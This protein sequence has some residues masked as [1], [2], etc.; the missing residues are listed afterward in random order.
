MQTITMAELKKTVWLGSLMIGLA[1]GRC[2][3]QGLIID[4]TCTDRSQIPATW[5]QQAQASFRVGYSHTS[6]GSQIVTGLEALRDTLGGTYDFTSSAWGQQAGVFLCDYWANEAGGADL[7]QSGDLTWRDA[8]VEML[9]R[10]D[11][12]RNLVMWSWCGGVSGNTE[13]GINAYLQAMAEL[14]TLYPGITFVYMTGHLDGSGVNGNLNVRNNQIRQFC[15]DH[16]KVLFDFADI[17]SYD[18]NGNA[19]LARGADD[20]CNYDGGNWAEEWCAAH[21]GNE[22]C[23]SCDCAHSQPLNCNRKGRAFWWMMARLAGWSGSSSNTLAAPAGVTAS[24]GAYTDRVRISWTG[25]TAADGYQLWRSQQNNSATAAQVGTA[26][27]TNYEDALAISGL[28][29]FYWVKAVQ[30]T[31]ISAFSDS[32]G[33]YSGVLGS[34][35]RVPADYDGDRAADPALYQGPTAGWIIWLS[36]ADYQ[37]SGP[38]VFG[39]SDALAAPG[40]FDGDGRAD[41]AAFQAGNW[42]VWLSANGYQQ[43]GPFNWGAAGDTPAPG[44][45]DG[46]GRADPAV[47]QAGQWT[48]WLSMMGYEMAGPFAFGDT[49]ITPVPGDYDGDGQTDPAVF[50]A[51]NWTVWLSSGGYAP[52]GPLAFGAAGDAPA[53]GD[54]DG[55]RATDPAV[56]Q[57]TTGDWTVWLSSAGYQMLG[58]LAFR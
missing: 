23:A 40:D 9:N 25:V 43:T 34:S 16:N 58:P 31:N 45:Y 5:I 28:L 6:H 24:D 29:Y 51:G 14:E 55:D 13:S 1:A 8:T 41:P 10:A 20:N 18:P 39:T 47:W 48:L 56:Y 57:T 53:P 3:A 15:R 49:S 35:Q 12:D 32:D 38:Y 54:Y 42:N 37:R 27:T 44:D 17:E 33:G 50:A 26:T 52:L 11:N 4:H 2:P 30:S 36:A 7:G 21:P 22:L 19:F 46:D